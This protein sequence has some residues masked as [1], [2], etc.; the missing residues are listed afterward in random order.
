[1]KEIIAILRPEKIRKTK[2][3]LAQKGF[4][5][6]TDERVLGRGKQS[7]LDYA[8]S[9]ARPAKESGISFLPKRL[10]TLF[11]NDEHLDAVLEIIHEANRTGEIGDGKIFVAP[12]AEAVRIRTDECDREALVNLGG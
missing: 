6:C 8:G 2:E 12:L 5:A 1:M 4:P 7:G 9:G 3:K 10:V 11:V